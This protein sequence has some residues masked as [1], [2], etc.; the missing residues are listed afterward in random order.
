M[1]RCES[2]YES[3]GAPGRVLFLM[4]R[5]YLFTQNVLFTLERTAGQGRAIL[6]G[7]YYLLGMHN[8]SG[9]RYLLR[10]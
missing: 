8:L 5:T 3:A 1:G 9:M 6:L 2:I 7:T 10:T 4:P